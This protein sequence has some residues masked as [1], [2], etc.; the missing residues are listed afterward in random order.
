AFA[1]RD[2]R[3]G[4]VLAAAFVLRDLTERRRVEEHLRQAQ[5]MEAIGRVAGGV[6]H[7]INNMM[8]VILGFCT[9]LTKSLEEGDP[10]HQD[11]AQ[12]ARAADRAAEVSRQLLAFSR[13]QLLQPKVLELNTVLLDLESVLRRL[14]GEDR[15]LVLRLAPQLGWVRTDRTQL[16][17]VILNLA[18]NARDAM[19]HGGRLAI[20]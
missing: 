8:T 15:D 4:R 5:R 12:I 2:A 9:F 13:R 14:M 20:E 16:E 7:E 18:L 3:S 10:R 19:P 6:A 17:Q 1:I 11:V